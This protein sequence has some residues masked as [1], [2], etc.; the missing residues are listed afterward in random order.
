MYTIIDC[1][2]QQWF[3]FINS[4]TTTTHG[5][6]WS[7]GVSKRVLMIGVR[8]RKGA[9]WGPW[10]NPLLGSERESSLS[11]VCIIGPQCYAY[12]IRCGL[13]LQ[14][15]WLNY[16]ARG[17]GSLY[18]RGLKG[19]SSSPESRGGVPDCRPGVFK[20]SMH[21]VW[22]LWHLSSVL[23]LD[24][25]QQSGGSQQ[26]GDGPQL[27]GTGSV[28]RGSG[29]RIR[30]ARSE[31]RRDPANLTPAQMSMH[32]CDQ[33]GKACGVAWCNQARVG[34]RGNEVGLTFMVH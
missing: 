21:S 15:Q 7:H 27:W 19:R 29:S 1:H 18:A 10:A 24:S 8:L 9:Q 11:V 20:Y 6:P 22:L 5:S 30:N 14:M 31:I 13:L 28:I 2:D 17:G 4:G 33:S 25:T 26:E 16:S 3:C 23:C 32:D 12:S 34:G